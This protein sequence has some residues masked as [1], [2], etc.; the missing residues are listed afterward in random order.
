MQLPQ[1]Q[2]LSSIELEY[3]GL[4]HSIPIPAALHSLACSL[5][6][7]FIASLRRDKDGERDEESD[8]AGVA[9]TTEELL[10]RFLVYLSGSEA[11]A[12]SAAVLDALNS[13]LRSDMDIHS[14]VAGTSGSSLLK[15]EM[16]RCYYK[17][18]GKTGLSGQASIA[19]ALFVAAADKK[20]KV[21]AVFGGQGTTEDLLEELRAVYLTY[22][23]LV[24]SLFRSASK[25][26][27]SLSKDDRTEGLYSNTGFDFLDWLQN[28]NHQPRRDG[29]LAPA[30]SFPLIGILSLAH[31]IVFCKVLKITPFDARK[32]FA[33]IT[34][35]SQGIVVAA[36]IASAESWDAL[37]RTSAEAITLLFWIGLRSQQSWTPAMPPPSVSKSL[38]Y[39]EDQITSMLRIR[40]LSRAAVQKQLDAVNT[41]LPDGQGIHISLINGRTNII[42]AGPPTSLC[43][44]CRLLQN[45]PS[46]KDGNESKQGHSVRFLSTTA[47][48]HS[49]YLREARRLILQ[50]VRDIELPRERLGVPVYDTRDG[51][52]LQQSSPRRLVDDLVDMITMD[53]VDWPQAT[54]FPG[55]THV[56]DF[57]PG[58]TSGVGAILRENFEGMG[59]RVILAS[60]LFGPENGLGSKTELFTMD[61]K[62]VKYEVSWANEYSPRL[63]STP[64]GLMIDNKYTRFFGM[65]PLMVAGMTPTTAH[66]DLVSATIN[67]GYHVE[68]A[69]GGYFDSSAMEAAI[70]RVCETVTPGHG[71]TCNLIYASPASMAWQ[72]PMVKKLIGQGVNVEGITIGAGVPSLDVANEYIRSLG[73][74]HISFKPGT[75]EAMQQVIVIAK[76]NPEF[77]VI[78]QWT[79]GRGGGHHSREDF[80][81][82]L[83]E[84]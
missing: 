52:N 39:D 13:M 30:I 4:N 45:A 49:P 65:P 79:G 19:P 48:F 38:E 28:P 5:R 51:I 34:G 2:S 11:E 73:L 16:L 44:L 56:V 40:G 15:T 35:H 64:S 26:L 31:Y 50:D 6:D 7:E 53:C 27:S 55:A 84:M 82:P 43:G 77:P 21:Y 37:D 62:G 69:G 9:M 29:I 20:A 36:A 12:V 17:I 14:V 70:K 18:Q 75:A 42:V 41:H 3:E 67:A 83:I 46:P 47:P 66:W 22:K 63:L 23:P 32:H 74:H 57:G 80:H 25:L 8:E 72:I 68:L 81:K 33:G 54:T 1:T 60:V 61:P 10:L 71:V 24:E 78:L 58:G 59:V 76:A